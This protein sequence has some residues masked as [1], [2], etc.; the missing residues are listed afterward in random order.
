M[1]LFK[2][3]TYTCLP[4]L[5]VPRVRN[6]PRATLHHLNYV[7]HWDNGTID[8][9]LCA[10]IGAGT[11]DNPFVIYR[12]PHSI[13]ADSHKRLRFV[14]VSD[15][16]N[17]IDKLTIPDG[18]VFVHCG[19]AV[20]FCS[21]A[22]D[23]LRFNKFVGTLPH[24]HKLFISGNHCV[25]L[26]PERPDLTQKIL[27]NMTYIQDQIIDIEGIRIYGSPWQPK[28]GLFYLSNAFSYPSKKIKEDKWS[29]IPE[30]IDILLTHSPPYSIRDYNPVTAEHSG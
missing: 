19:D 23:L 16:H 5:R 3:S 12:D 22:R 9:A 25:S 7:P 15:T 21:S 26:N 30:N 6:H 20:K 29:H 28:R 4:G 11:E 27:S 24:T 1:S 14:C 2:L 17:Q 18:D 10:R 13:D 8:S